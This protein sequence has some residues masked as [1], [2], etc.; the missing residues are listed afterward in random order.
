VSRNHVVKPMI[1]WKDE[2]DPKWSMDEEGKR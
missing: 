1:E 2:L